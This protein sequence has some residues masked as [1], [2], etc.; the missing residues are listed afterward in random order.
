MG[1]LT[2]RLPE[3]KHERL[4]Q[5]ALRRN[6]SMNKLIEELSTVALTEFDAETRFRARAAMGSA[7]EGLRLLDE[8]ERTAESAPTRP[9]RAPSPPRR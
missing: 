3:E 6:I 1:T 8:L 5:L 2:I 4:R 7:Q 9:R